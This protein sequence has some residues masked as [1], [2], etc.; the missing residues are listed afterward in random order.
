MVRA[1][2]YP[3]VPNYPESSLLYFPFS[4]QL[5]QI[6]PFIP[7]LTAMLRN[8]SFRIP[9]LGSRRGRGSGPT[10]PYVEDP[11]LLVAGKGRAVWGVLVGQGQDGVLIYLQHFDVLKLI[12]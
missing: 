12:N 10:H 1:Y 6:V 9:E 5:P 4:R 7:S 8:A 11:A 3:A 2:L